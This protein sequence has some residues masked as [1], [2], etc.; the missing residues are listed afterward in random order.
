MLMPRGPSQ[1]VTL[2]EQMVAIAILSVMF[3][4]A[5]PSFGDWI[6]NTRLRSTAETLRAD[7]QMARAEAIR[8]NTT[9]RLQFVSSLDNSCVLSTG[10][11]AWVVNAGAAQNPEGACNADIGTNAAPFLIRKSTGVSINNAD[12]QLEATRSTLGFDSLGRQ[13]ATTAPATS[14]AIATVTFTSRK[15]TC[16]AAGGNVRCLNV[17]LSPGGDSRICDPS[18]TASTDPMRC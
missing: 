7:L 18:R 16:V 15:G 8:R 2:I 1:G 6:R 5:L 17:V 9:T 10:G 12:L 11:S 4:I 14:V 3:A 13:T